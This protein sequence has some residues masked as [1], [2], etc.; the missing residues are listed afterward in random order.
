MTL[1]MAL[2]SINS[3]T[4][5]AF[6]E[7]L[8]SNYMRKSGQSIKYGFIIDLLFFFFTCPFGQASRQFHLPDS[9]FTCPGLRASGLFRRLALLLQKS[10]NRKISASCTSTYYSY[11]IDQ[12]W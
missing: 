7:R 6:Y 10:L 3:I 2:Y 5:S 12:V 4:V 1:I 11:D 9:N 8:P